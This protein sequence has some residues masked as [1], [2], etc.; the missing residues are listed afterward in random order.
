MIGPTA[1]F[2]RAN[3][4]RCPTFDL[5][6]LGKNYK[7]RTYTDLH[8]LLLPLRTIPNSPIFCFIAI[9]SKQYKIETRLFIDGKFTEGNKKKTFS[10]QNPATEEV[11]AE[12]HEADEV[13]VDAAVTAAKK[14]QPSWEK[15]PPHY[16]AD[17]LRKLADLIK[18]DVE[19]LGYLESVSMGR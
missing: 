7:L 2:D 17:L 11:V 16:K 6:N 14:A 18:R 5:I 15:S 13:D 4:R 3:P 19:E 10:L 8:L 1:T 12:V 9:M